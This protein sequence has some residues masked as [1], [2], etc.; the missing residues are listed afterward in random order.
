M[1]TFTRILHF[2]TGLLMV[3]GMFLV[4]VEHHNDTMS[5]G[6]ADNA[7]ERNAH[8]LAVKHKCW[9]SG[10]KPLV[11]IPG[12]SIQFDADGA[13]YYAGLADTSKALDQI[14]NSVDHG[15]H[16]YAFCV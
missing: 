13:A 11:S 1:K 8:T 3:A 2:V 14:W 6:K 4:A 5:A 15:L 16:P 9:T 7:Q 10:E 12:H